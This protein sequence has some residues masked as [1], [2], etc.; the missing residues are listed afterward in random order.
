MTDNIKEF[1]C[2]Y[3]N[4]TGYIF[5][6]PDKSRN[7]YKRNCPKC[8]GAG[9]LDW[10]EIIVGKRKPKPRTLKSSW[11]IDV[12]EQLNCVF[13]HDLADNIAQ[14]IADDIDKMIMDELLDKGNK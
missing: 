10:I 11:D 12:L 14:Q 3:C 4:G 2:N 1:K 13:G 7:S 5:T 6:E 8:Y 9:T